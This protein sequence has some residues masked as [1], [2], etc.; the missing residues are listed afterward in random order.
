MEAPT[1]AVRPDTPGTGGG[2]GD[3]RGPG[4]DVSSSGEHG[5]GGLLGPLLG[6]GPGLGASGSGG[7]SGTTSGSGGGGAGGSSSGGSGGGGG[8]V[9]GG[10]GGSGSSGSSAALETILTRLR[11][12]H[13]RETFG[14][15]MSQ[16]AFYTIELDDADDSAF[17]PLIQS[18]SRNPLVC[19]A[20][21]NRE[22]FG[23]QDSGL[24][25]SDAG[26]GPIENDILGVLLDQ[27]GVSSEEV[28]LTNLQDDGGSCDDR[29][30]TGTEDSTWSCN[31]CWHSLCFAWC[32]PPL[33]F[34][35]SSHSVLLYLFLSFS[36][37]FMFD[38]FISLAL[39]CSLSLSLSLSVLCNSLCLSFHRWSALAQCLLPYFARRRFIVSHGRQPTATWPFLLWPEL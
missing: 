28:S 7:G 1:A 19:L 29:G 26:A 10:G 13:F 14:T 31:I 34:F 24:V 37:L 2:G 6:S 4:G 38:L 21:L 39:F 27:L 22:L 20:E 17:K 33:Q 5:G 18:Q 32:H 36:S 16:N 35:R 8:G 25:A 9:S 12:N 23:A 30:S 15:G 11:A 3:S